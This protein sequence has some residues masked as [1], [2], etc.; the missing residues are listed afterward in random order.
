MSK[1]LHKIL[2]NLNKEAGQEKLLEY[3]NKQLDGEKLHEFE[4]HLLDDPFM[5]DAAEGLDLVKDKEDLSNITKQL[6]RD[7]KKQLAGRKKEKQILFFNQPWAYVAIILIIFL[8]LIAFFV[9][10][11][12]GN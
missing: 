7:L 6:N 5:N 2:G 8:I 10:R 12:L 11:K 4:K 1:D 9:L 3:L